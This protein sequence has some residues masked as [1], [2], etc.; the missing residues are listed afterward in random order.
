[1]SKRDFLRTEVDGRVGI[2]NLRSVTA[3][4][5]YTEPYGD[6]STY[7]RAD[8]TAH[9]LDGSGGS[10]SYEWRVFQGNPTECNAYIEWL[11]GEVDALVY[12]TSGAAVAE[13]L[14]A[15]V[16]AA[17][18]RYNADGVQN[19]NY[20]TLLCDARDTYQLDPIELANQ[21]R[22]TVRDLVGKGM[23]VVTGD[24]AGPVFNTKLVYLRH[25][26]LD[27][28]APTR[29][30]VRDIVATLDMLY[31]QGETEVPWH[32]LEDLWNVP[33]KTRLVSAVDWL[34]DNCF[35]T[36]VVYR[37]VDGEPRVLSLLEGAREAFR[38]YDL[39]HTNNAIKKS[40]PY[41]AILGW[42]RDAVDIDKSDLRPV[43]G[44]AIRKLLNSAVISSEEVDGR[45]YYRIESRYPE[46][47]RNMVS[48][49]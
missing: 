46:E 22:D 25:V 13:N 30:A 10:F 18:H 27:H 16:L 37:Y 34:R 9:E 19:V 5:T 6:E 3:I 45:A 35:I 33:H 4:H 48:E 39:M 38:V 43:V 12:P 17:M 2:L 41:E 47:L 40:V 14:A 11:C 15:F 21:L 32:K 42:Y 24:I 36:E 28:T 29:H 26:G 7:V 1:M 44:D 23:I 31:V 20:H 8:T 49:D